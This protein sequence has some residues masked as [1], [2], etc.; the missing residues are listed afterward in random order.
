M[1]KKLHIRTAVVTAAVAA[2]LSLT[3]CGLLSEQIQ[4]QE[5]GGVK[6]FVYRVSDE[7][8]S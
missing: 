2:S 4:P 6:W 7:R 5:G 3:G 1:M 8:T